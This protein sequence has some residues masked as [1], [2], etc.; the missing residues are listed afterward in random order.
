MRFLSKLM[1]SDRVE[2][3]TTIGLILFPDFNMQDIVGPYEI[4]GQTGGFVICT[5]SENT[6]ALRTSGGLSVSADFSFDECPLLDVLFV[7]GGKGITGAIDRGAY[8]AFLQRQS[9]HAK[10]VVAVSLGALLLAS[11]GVLK[12]Y[13]VTTAIQSLP[14]LAEM[15]LMTVE[16]PIAIDGNRITG[17]GKISGAEVSLV[18]MTLMEMEERIRVDNYRKRLVERAGW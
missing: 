6:Q 9:K 10:F 1:D 13:R 12:G 15:G 17:G 2:R 18:L 5:I 14:L 7:P 4:F 16:D 8:K 11:S 3:K